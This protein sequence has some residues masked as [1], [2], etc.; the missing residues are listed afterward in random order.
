MS[1]MDISLMLSDTII[2]KEGD[3][4]SEQYN[5]VSITLQHQEC[6]VGKTEV[7]GIHIDD[8]E[9]GRWSIYDIPPKKYPKIRLFYSTVK[10][11]EH[12]SW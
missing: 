11:T 8:N 7:S 12:F 2:N 4:E 5:I 1:G 9:E 3:I 6:P 10:L